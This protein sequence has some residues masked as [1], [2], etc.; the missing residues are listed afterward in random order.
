MAAAQSDSEMGTNV[1]GRS[2]MGSAAPPGGPSSGHG[3]LGEC[4]TSVQKR[5][6]LRIQVDPAFQKSN[7]PA[8]VRGPKIVLETRFRNGVKVTLQNGLS[9]I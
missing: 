1:G 6:P 2:R 4:S 7:T 5:R 3:D 9:P 8:L